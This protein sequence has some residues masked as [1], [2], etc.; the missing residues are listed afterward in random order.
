MKQDE[1]NPNLDLSMQEDHQEN[2]TSSR[3]SEEGVDQKEDQPS[4]EQILQEENARLKDQ[5]LRQMAEGENLKKRTQR[6]KE[7][8]RQYAITNFAR[9][10]LSVADNLQRALQALTGM[11]DA[12]STAQKNFIEGVRLTERELESIFIRQ[13]IKKV[14]PMGE[15][16]DHNFH[17][18]MFETENEDQVPGTVTQVLQEGYVLQERLLRPAMVGVAKARIG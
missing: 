8:A 14:S 6:E 9:D 7:E 4:T 5:L 10:L 16:F 15:K 18:A 12:F 17:Q 1:K 2:E 13:G 11:E 3:T